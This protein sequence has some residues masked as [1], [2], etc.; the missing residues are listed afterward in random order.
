MGMK[1]LLWCEMV[2]TTRL[3]VVRLVYFMFVWAVIVLG[4]K[5]RIPLEDTALR[6]HHHVTMP[7]SGAKRMQ[8]PPENMSSH[9]R[10]LQNDQL[11]KYFYI[12]DDG[13]QGAWHN[14][15]ILS[16]NMRDDPNEILEI[17]SNH[18]AG[19]LVNAERGA[20]H[21]DQ[22]QLFLL[23]FNRA[24]HDWRRT[25]DPN[26]A[27]TFIIPYDFASDVSYYKKCARN[28]ENTCLDFR[29]CPMASRVEDLLLQSPFF[30][31]KLGYDHVLF[32]GNN[33]AQEHYIGKPAC[34]KFLSGVCFNC[35]KLAIDDYSFLHSGDQGMVTKGTN[36]SDVSFSNFAKHLNILSHAGTLS[37]SPLISIGLAM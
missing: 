2:V 37:R 10:R 17:V 22:Y 9:S 31:N 4:D 29:K 35:T 15:S 27:T 28:K 25:Y 33:Y 19:P 36:W 6:A 14:I 18:G 8:Q 26:V 21:T 23:N 1:G 12:Y 5:E 30:H 11:P 7:V 16:T 13:P 20:Y 3:C 34:K 32:I 24:Q